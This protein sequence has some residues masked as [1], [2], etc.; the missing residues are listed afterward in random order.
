[1]VYIHMVYVVMVY[2]VMVYIVMVYIHM[3]YIVMAR[4]GSGA[5]EGVRHQLPARRQAQVDGR[6]IGQVR[7]RSIY[8]IM[9]YI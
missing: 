5:A 2:T 8:M 3:V 4:R 6:P 1:M 7:G 9:V